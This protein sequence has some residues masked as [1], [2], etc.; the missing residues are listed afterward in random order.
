[1][2]RLQVFHTVEIFVDLRGRAG[3][4]R[5]D[6]PAVF[7]LDTGDA[8]HKRRADRQHPE[9]GDPH[10]PVINADPYDRDHQ[11]R[12]HANGI[13]QPV[14]ERVFHVCEI[15]GKGT[16]QF[17]R[18]LGRKEPQRLAAQFLDVCHALLGR[19][20]V[21][22]P[23]GEVVGDQLYRILE[24][25]I[26]QTDRRK[27]DKAPQIQ[28]VRRHKGLPQSIDRHVCQ[29]SREHTARLRKEEPDGGLDDLLRLMKGELPDHLKHSPRLLSSAS[30][31]FHFGPPISAHTGR[32]SAAVPGASPVLSASRRPERR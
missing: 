18:L 7:F 25:D 9:H 5:H 13:G 29:N 14:A 19:I 21:S 16:D 26:S 30:F 11:Q 8:K 3:L 27:H 31:R 23:I 28:C 2:V 17:A 22:A 1:M 6:L 15:A 10:A 12:P 32:P 24:Q 20:A 4:R